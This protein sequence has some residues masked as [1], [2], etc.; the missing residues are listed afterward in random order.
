MIPAES[1]G[2]GRAAWSLP[3]QGSEW[4]GPRRRVESRAAEGRSE[5][6]RSVLDAAAERRGMRRLAATT[7]GPRPRAGTRPRRRRRGRSKP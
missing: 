7:A 3:A 5:G 2:R 6:P 1:S 4:L